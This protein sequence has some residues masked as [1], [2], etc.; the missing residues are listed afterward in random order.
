ML[1]A[2]QLVTHNIGLQISEQR[3][4]HVLRAPLFSHGIDD[5]YQSTNKTNDGDEEEIVEHDFIFKPQTDY[6]KFLE[7]LVADPVITKENTKSY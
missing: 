6:E 3:L 7:Q 1:C 4:A 5:R 2:S